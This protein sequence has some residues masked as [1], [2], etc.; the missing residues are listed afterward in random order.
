M[1][2]IHGLSFVFGLGCGV[3]TSIIA[4]I[5]AVCFQAAKTE[6]RRHCIIGVDPATGVDK[7]VVRCGKCG[8]MGGL[9]RMPLQLA[10]RRR[11][12]RACPDCGKV[13][14]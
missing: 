6:D 2:Q 12:V 8:W 7:T 14:A 9:D 1:E 13:V 3:L 5:A 10:R 4:V 11:G